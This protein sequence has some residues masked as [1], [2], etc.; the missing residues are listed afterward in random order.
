MPQL[1]RPIDNRCTG[2]ARPDRRASPAGLPRTA[3][4][5][6]GVLVALHLTFPCLTFSFRLHIYRLTPEVQTNLETMSN[7]Q[8]ESVCATPHPSTDISSRWRVA[9]VFF[10][11][12]QLVG[13]VPP[14]S[15]GHRPSELTMIP[16]SYMMLAIVI[17]DTS[18][19]L[20]FDR[21]ATIISAI[22]II[23]SSLLAL[24]WIACAKWQQRDL[25]LHLFM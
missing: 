14:K 1:P 15:N 16:C 2:F 5:A 3:T 18:H 25:L 20:R 23:A 8:Y 6:L 9:A 10:P 4:S 12:A 11:A 22:L 21:K 17:G 7:H 24:V 19:E 13:S